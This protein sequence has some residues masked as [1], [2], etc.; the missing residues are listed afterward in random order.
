MLVESKNTINYVNYILISA[1]SCPDRAHEGRLSL[2]D[3]HDICRPCTLQ[4]F[5]I[6]SKQA[7]RFCRFIFRLREG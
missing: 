5:V 2:E 6:R 3:G 1:I 7:S 4:L